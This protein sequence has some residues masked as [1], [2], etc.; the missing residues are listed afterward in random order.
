MHAPAAQYIYVC[1]QIKVVLWVSTM[2]YHFYTQYHRLCHKPIPLHNPYTHSA[3]PL[4]LQGHTNP[5]YSYPEI[6]AGTPR[7]GLSSYSP[8]AGATPCSIHFASTSSRQAGCPRAGI[9]H[10]PAF[11][12]SEVAL[13]A[14]NS[15]HNVVGGALRYHIIVTRQQEADLHERDEPALGL[16]EHWG[17]VLQLCT[18]LSFAGEETPLKPL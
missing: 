12:F 15:E 3:R 2:Y 5:R 8:R 7:V 6:Y 9:C 13:C 11:A 16:V 10:R 18:G 14:A 17:G 1:C 4:R